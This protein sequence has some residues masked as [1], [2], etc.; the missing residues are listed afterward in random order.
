V[1][2]T[3]RCVKEKGLAAKVRVAK[4]VVAVLGRLRVLVIGLNHG[5][6]DAATFIRPARYRIQ[7]IVRRSHDEQGKAT[8]EEDPRARMDKAPTGGVRPIQIRFSTVSMPMTMD[9]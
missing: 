7:A 9:N 5:Q 6:K 4:A 2:I 8:A 3:R 1:S